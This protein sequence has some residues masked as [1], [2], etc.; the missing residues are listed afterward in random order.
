MCALSYVSIMSIENIIYKH[1]SMAT[2]KRGCFW[3]YPSPKN[4]PANCKDKVKVTKENSGC[5]GADGVGR[6]T[7]VP[8]RTVYSG[9]NAQM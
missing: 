1:C 3:V 4:R 7:T 6:P 9:I 2:E 5:A 8:S